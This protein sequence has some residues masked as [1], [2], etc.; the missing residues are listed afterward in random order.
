M[1]RAKIFLFLAL[2][3]VLCA[4]IVARMAA[5]EPEREPDA[6]TYA[7][8]VT[9]ESSPVMLS[10]VKRGEEPTPTAEQEPEPA[11]R[12]AGIAISDADKDIL[13]CLA[14]HEARGESFEGQVAVIEVV[15]NRCMSGYFPD[16]V[17]EVVFQRLGDVWQ[18]SPAPYLW[19]AEPGAAQYDAVEA[20][21]T[22]T[23][24]NVTEDTVFFSTAPYN[25]HVSAV[26]GNHYFC[27][28]D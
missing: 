27:T 20:A 12:Y 21:L 9:P 6:I 26:I 24:Y 13:A 23:E 5:D 14:Y 3:A 4:L 2:V 15:L 7:A 10:T 1:R 28:V 11:S 8:A 17:E 18:F 19:T 16:T 25:D 22:E